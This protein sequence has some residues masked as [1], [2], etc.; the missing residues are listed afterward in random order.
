MRHFTL[1]DITMAVA[2]IAL[3]FFVAMTVFGILEHFFSEGK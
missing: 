2:V 3:C 1:E